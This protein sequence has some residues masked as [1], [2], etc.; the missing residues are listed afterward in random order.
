M[1]PYCGVDPETGR[2]T[3]QS[4]TAVNYLPVPVS[5]GERIVPRE[6]GREWRYYFY[7]PEIPPELVHTYTYEPES[8][9]T[10]YCPE[11]SASSWLTG[12]AVMPEGGYV[13]LALRG[14]SGETDPDECFIREAPDF[15][16]EG[17]PDAD[18]RADAEG[19]PDAD[20]RADAEG[21]GD[22]EELSD[23]PPE[24]MR[25][26]TEKTVS[27]AREAMREDTLCY[28]LLADSHYT[29]GGIWPDTAESLRMTAGKLSPLGIIHLGDMSDGLLP[30]SYTKFLARL[31]REDL[32]SVCK[33]VYGCLGNHDLNY[34][35]G[36]PGQISKKSAAR[37]YLGREDL[38]YAE[39][40]P[41]SRL[42]LL[43]LDSFDPGEKERY[44]FDKEELRWLRGTLRRTPKGW[45]VLVFSHVTPVSSLH[46][47]SDT[48]RGGE[49]ILKILESFDRKRGGAVIG[50]IHGH[51]HTDQIWR[52][53]S[54]P[55]I[56]IGCSKLEDFKE[57]KPPGAV[58]WEREQG[59]ETQ[60]LWDV[61]LIH[62]KTGDMDL[63][64]FG[65]GEDRHIRRTG[66]AVS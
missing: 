13:R 45:K 31:M 20:E 54:F 32:A 61:L 50:W 46:V 3:D 1:F 48:I 18:E 16:P 33:N 49:K 37:L 14:G 51:N 58:T 9:W 19:R 43:F 40:L 53:A 26:Q 28:F 24:W 57:H 41:D 35:R 5:A 44:G 6:P 56:G 27:R 8:N 22:T 21:R 11:R 39:D 52:G 23:A 62:S 15:A 25:A 42:R 64:R 34:F 12:P 7:A 2:L 66:G 59:T 4:G 65:A 29:A 55:V 10:V 36:N 38:W 60:E 63:I 47:W 17:R 30:V